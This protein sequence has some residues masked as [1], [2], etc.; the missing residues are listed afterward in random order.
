MKWILLFFLIIV[1]KAYSFQEHARVYFKDKPNASALLENPSTILSARSIER[2]KAHNVLIDHKDVPVHDDYIA[3][4]ANREGI[5]VL[6]KS[7][8]FNCI[9]VTGSVTAIKNLNGMSF[10]GQI[11]FVNKRLNDGE[12]LKSRSE[13]QRIYKNKFDKETIINSGYTSAQ[14]TQIGVPELHNAGFRGEGILIAVLDAGFPGVDFMEAFRKLRMGNGFLNSYDFVDRTSDISSYKGNQHGT[15]VLSTMA[16]YL[17]DI[18]MGSAP[19]ASYVLF[20]TEEAEQETPVEESYWVEAAERADSLGVDIINTS[21]GYSTFDNPDYSYF[22]EE[23]DGQTTFISKGAGIALDKG[24]LLVTSAG[25]EGNNLAWEIV[26]APADADVLTV[27]AVDAEGNYASFSSRGP[28]AD[29]RV[30]PDVMAQGVATAVI[31][32]DDSMRYA[33]GTSF[34]SPVVA[35]A[36]ACLWQANPSLSNEAIIQLVRKSG[37][38]YDHPNNFYGF[39]IPNLGFWVAGANFSQEIASV[40]FSVFPNPTSGKFEVVFPEQIKYAE[41]NLY[42]IL[43]KWVFNKDISSRNNE[44]NIAHLNSGVYI[45]KIT[46]KN[47]EKTLK[48]IKQ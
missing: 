20:R 18:Y 7:K 36:V 41:I 39:G 44:I 23:M 32:P 22:P 14:L 46:S 10:V 28:T 40:E 31:L 12:V 27:G 19:D 1:S 43:G 47:A 35:G 15:L 6:A 24:M 33:N 45:A 13:S 4:V 8:W 21:L 29:L 2:K 26:T 42:D 3:A 48:I 11:V 5:T 38:L 17:K 34:S 9:H 30:K 16:A 37:H 25:N